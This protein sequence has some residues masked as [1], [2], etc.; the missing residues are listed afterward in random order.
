ML[1]IP[2]ILNIL[3]ITIFL[4]PFHSV[5]VRKPTQRSKLYQASHGPRELS[6]QDPSGSRKEDKARK[7]FLKLNHVKCL[8]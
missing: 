5:V 6:S 4:L 7:D 8:A 1:I 3:S 2:K